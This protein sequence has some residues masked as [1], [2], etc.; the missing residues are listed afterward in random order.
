MSTMGR[1][2]KQ[3]INKDIVELD[4]ALDEID[5]MIYI[6]H[7]MY[8]YVY[9]YIQKLSSQGSKIHSLFKCMWNIFKDSPDD[10]T[11]NKPQE[12]QEN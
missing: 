6:Y 4:N 9:I 10:G 5:L 3:N 12:I 11:Q 2:S 8:I 1:S 7:Y